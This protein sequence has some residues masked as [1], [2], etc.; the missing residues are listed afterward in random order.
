[1][2]IEYKNVRSYVYTLYH[3]HVTRSDVV[4]TLHCA[5]AKCIAQY[6]PKSEKIVTKNDEGHLGSFV[7]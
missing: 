5:T 6:I 1:M 7:T 4:I 3:F 2:R